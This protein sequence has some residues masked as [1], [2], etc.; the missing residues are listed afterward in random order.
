M[1][2]QMGGIYATVS[3]ATDLEQLKRDVQARLNGIQQTMDHYLQAQLQ[4]YQEV[5]ANEQQLKARLNLL[6]NE[7][8]AL[9]ERLLEAHRAALRDAVTGLPNRLAYDE[10]VVQEFARWKRFGE[11][12]SMLVWDVDNF[13]SINDR[14]GHQAGDK[15]LRVIANCLQQR[16]RETDFIGRYGGEEF[17][18]LLC[19][20]D[21]EEAR[22]LAEQMRESVMHSGFHS[23]G[24]A[25]SVTI[26]CGISQ[27]TRGDSV[28]AV[29]KRADAAVYQAKR[30]GKN[31]CELG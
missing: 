26:S 28:E 15:T 6:D 27:F 10:R 25:V 14:F 16:L 12:L 11:P 23:G 5:D 4:W 24:K 2:S 29:F 1:T 30:R 20:A 18:T 31:R 17:V 8:A 13:K 21:A 19:G 9:R 7:A 22:R 3:A